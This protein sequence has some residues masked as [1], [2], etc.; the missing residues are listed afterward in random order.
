MP[1]QRRRA[2]RRTAAPGRVRS[3][4]VKDE[5]GAAEAELAVVADEL[6]CQR[7]VDRTGHVAT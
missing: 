4:S 6:A 2:P 1:G 7:P 3:G 5:T